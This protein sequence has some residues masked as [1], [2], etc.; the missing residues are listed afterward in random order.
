VCLGLGSLALA[1]ET[2]RE[3]KLII[4]CKEKKISVDSIHSSRGA[5]ARPRP[6]FCCFVSDSESKGFNNH[7]SEQIQEGEMMDS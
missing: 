5:A 7:H 3:S 2:Q 6:S 1:Q 4:F